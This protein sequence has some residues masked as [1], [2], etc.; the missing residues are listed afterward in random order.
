MKKRLQ[1]QYGSLRAAAVKLDINYYRLSQ[2]CNGWV[3]PRPE[4]TKK[5]KASEK[6]LNELRK[7]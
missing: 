7:T 3:K 1:D 6:E 2:I 4:E 5:L